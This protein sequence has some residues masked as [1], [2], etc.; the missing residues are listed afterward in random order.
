MFKSLAII[1]ALSATVWAQASTSV[2]PSGISTPCATFLKTFNED[3]SFSG[4]TSAIISATSTFTSGSTPSKAA[5]TSALDTLSSSKACNEN[6]IRTTLTEFY[7]ACSTELTSN[8]NKDVSIIYEVLYTLVPFK[9]ALCTKDN[10]DGSYCALKSGF[11]NPAADAQKYLAVQNEGSGQATR[12]NTTTFGNEHILFLN[13]KEDL[14]SPSLCVSCTRNVIT[15]YIQWESTI[16]YAPGLSSSQLLTGQSQLYKGVQSTCGQT[17]L[18][19]AVQA[20]GGLSGGIL[21]G[22]DN[23][24]ISSSAILEG[25]ITAVLGSVVTA[26]FTLL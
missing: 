26:L 23:G 24:A 6:K 11:G 19:G 3:T 20:A 13:L 9:N 16:N 21:G 18:S 1:S 17:F 10:D 22:H 15:T 14:P 2:I 25:A 7:S 12:L 8:L 4:C 5:V